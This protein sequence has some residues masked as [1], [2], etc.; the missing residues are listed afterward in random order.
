MDYHMSM[1][2]ALEELIMLNHDD[3][4]YWYNM[5]YDDNSKIIEDNIN[6]ENNKLIWQRVAY[7]IPETYLA[8]CYND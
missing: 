6:E 3:Y 1:G 7:N 4:D 8:G 2:E 5:M